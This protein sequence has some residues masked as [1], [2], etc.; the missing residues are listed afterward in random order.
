MTSL[1]TC[2]PTLKLTKCLTSRIETGKIIFSSVQF[3]FWSNIY[4]KRNLGTLQV[5][6]CLATLSVDEW[7]QP[8]ASSISCPPS[9]LPE[10][11]TSSEL[12]VW[13]PHTRK[14]EFCTANE[15]DSSVTIEQPLQNHLS[16]YFRIQDIAPVDFASMASKPIVLHCGEDIKWNHDLYQKLRHKFEIKRSCSMPRDDF[17]SALKS[18]N[19]GDFHARTLGK[20]IRTCQD[21][22]AL[23]STL[24]KHASPNILMNYNLIITNLLLN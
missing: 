15:L 3:M 20:I 18:K 7:L 8:G 13:T 24:L 16:F 17:I 5:L 2:G 22:R 11:S 4:M 1:G 21:L 23:R 6:T 19:F 12:V 9:P 14:I 10:S